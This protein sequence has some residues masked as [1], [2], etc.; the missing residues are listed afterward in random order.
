MKGFLKGLWRVFSTLGWI[1]A[2]FLFIPCLIAARLIV[3]DPELR[4]ISHYISQTMIYSPRGW[5][6]GLV[7][8]PLAAGVSL[9]FVLVIVTT[10]FLA[11]FIRGAIIKR[12]A[13]HYIEPEAR[14]QF[15]AVRRDRNAWEALAKKRTR[16]LREAEAR[17]KGAHDIM[18]HASVAV[19]RAQLALTALPADSTDEGGPYH[20]MRR[21]N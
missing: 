10:A 16:E 18:Q 11:A 9:L 14:K 5:E 17:L 7:A 2:G 13:H 19:G 3:N 8:A 12:N 15:L 1:V 21:V 4:G 20:P 6:L